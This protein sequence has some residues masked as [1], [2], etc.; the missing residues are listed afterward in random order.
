[1][2]LMLSENQ[3][4][5]LSTA[6]QQLKHTLPEPQQQQLRLMFHHQRLQK[7]TLP[8]PQLPPPKLM[9][10][11]LQPKPTSLQPLQLRHTFLELQRP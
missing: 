9:S 3:K 8:E 5:L 11:G 4:E 2:D 7:P 6:L 10:Q 1:M